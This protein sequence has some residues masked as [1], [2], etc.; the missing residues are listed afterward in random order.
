M[1]KLKLLNLDGNRIDD[2][3]EILK[4]S[5]LEKYDVSY[6]WFPTKIFLYR[7]L[8]HIDSSTSY[9]HFFFCSLETLILNNNQLTTISFPNLGEQFFLNLY[10]YR[11]LLFFC[12]RQFR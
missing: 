1:K 2:W 8:S 3:K 12:D 9:V 10:I 11:S 6:A 7:S 4:L 5:E